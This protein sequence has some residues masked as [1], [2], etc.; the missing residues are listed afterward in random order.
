M[1]NVA[2]AA[3]GIVEDAAHADWHLSL[4][5]FFATDAGGADNHAAI[6]DGLLASAAGDAGYFSPMF[7]AVVGTVFPGDGYGV[8]AGD[9]LGSALAAELG[10]RLV[11]GSALGASR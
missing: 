4:G 9:E 3:A 2:K 5:A 11:L 10:Y 1:G 7:P 8:G 6:T